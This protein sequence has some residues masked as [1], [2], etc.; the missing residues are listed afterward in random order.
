[1]IQSLWKN[2]LRRIRT[3]KL[4]RNAGWMLIGQ[5]FGFL[6]Q[7][8]YF[9]LLARLLGVREYGV[10]AGA[11]AFA[12][13][14]MPYSTLGSGILFVRYV[15]TQPENFAKFW[16]NILLSTTLA[17]VV[18]TGILH[19]AASHV[20]NA[21]SASIIIPVAIANCVFAQMVNSMGFV[22][23]AYE[24]L[25]MTAILGILTNAVRLL[26]VGV[27]AVTVHSATATQWATASLLASFL[28]AL[29]GFLVVTRIFAAPRFSIRLLRMHFTEGLGFSLGWSAQ[30]ISN[31]IDKTLLSH[32]GMNVQNGIYST[33]YRIVDVATMPIGAL[34]S[35]ALPRYVRDSASSAATVPRLA[36]RL[37]TRAFLVGLLVSVGLFVSAPLIPLALGHS[38]TDA[39]RTLRWLCLLPAMRGVHYLTGSA[40]TG[41]GLQRYRTVAQ[42]GAALLNLILNLWLIPRD[43]WLGA[44]WASLATD[45]CLAIGTC[46]LLSILSRRVSLPAESI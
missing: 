16:G 44:A 35:A 43:G 7:A 21:A 37:A 11:F 32:Y 18:L 4:G 41:V 24:R 6:L 28:A 30:S 40:L 8:A 15:G 39:V 46:S 45:G 25:K 33:A 22:F 5:G 10:F 3:S 36:W 1:M 27:L 29:I 38:F 26:A 14:A 12:G 19:A 9:I 20:L 23:M 34:D 42:V 31:D 17:G 13:I 2:E